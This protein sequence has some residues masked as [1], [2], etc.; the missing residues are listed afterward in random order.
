MAGSR[1]DP[2]ETVARGV[3]SRRAVTA[4]GTVKTNVFLG[5]LGSQ[6]LSVDR[7]DFAPEGELVRLGDERARNRNRTFYGWA[8]LLV[9]D[10]ERGGEGV[11]VRATPQA[12]NPYHA[13]IVLPNS[14]LQARTTLAVRF[15]R[16][17]RWRP[18]PNTAG[19]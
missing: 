13:D 15:A 17:S 11:E 12:N 1:V 10:A 9:R 14:E 2:D 6:S 16:V 19:S 7:V 5:P 3:F 18:R 8:N 4:A